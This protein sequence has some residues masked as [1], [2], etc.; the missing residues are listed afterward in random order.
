MTHGTRNG[1]QRGKCRCEGCYA[2]HLAYW[3]KYMNEVR[4]GARGAE[5]LGRLRAATKKQNDRPDIKRALDAKN[6]ERRAYL[7][8]LK[9][10]PCMDC[11]GSF[12]P[13]CMDFDHRP[14]TVKEFDVGT[15][16]HR[17]WNRILGETEKCDVVCANCHRMRTVQRKRERRLRGEKISR[18][19]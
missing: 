10:R 8:T 2:A 12:H 17:N 14:G 19:Y 4:S 16:M 18:G 6:K 11:G 13:E 3:K 15:S 7:Y 5:R 9:Q 1:Y